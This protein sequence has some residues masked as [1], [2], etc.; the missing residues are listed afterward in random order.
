M[1]VGERQTIETLINE[2]ALLF[3][4]FLREEI[5]IWVPRIPIIAPRG[6]V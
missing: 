1:K 6:M 2:D 3:A 4:K 5:K